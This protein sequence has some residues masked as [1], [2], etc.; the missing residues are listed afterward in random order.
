MRQEV[1]DYKIDL[2]IDENSLDREFVHQ[3]HLYMK[4]AELAASADRAAKQAKEKVEV[5]RAQ[6]YRDVVE[7]EDKKPTESWINSKITLDDNYQDAMT[8][9]YDKKYEAD[10]MASAVKSMDHKKSALENLARLW[11]GSYFSTPKQTK[12]TEEVKDTSRSTRQRERM[13]R[14]ER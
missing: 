13:N 9:Y 4:Y 10:L 3:P 8:D 12:D 14:G 5:V 1:N 6:I 2:S 11:V 7:R